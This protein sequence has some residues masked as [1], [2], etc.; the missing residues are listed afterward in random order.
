MLLEYA[1]LDKKLLFLWMSTKCLHNRLFV[2]MYRGSLR[3]CF[4]GLLIAIID[5][6]WSESDIVDP[7]FQGGSF[8]MES[9]ARCLIVLT[10]L[11]ADRLELPKNGDWIVSRTL[12]GHCWAVGTA[13]RTAAC[14]SLRANIPCGHTSEHGRRTLWMCRGLAHLVAVI[15]IASCVRSHEWERAGQGILGR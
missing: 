10:S 8:R 9:I 12:Y 15:L 13:A 11:S 1:E 4:L 3:I 6:C 7:T 2:C 14:R 5:G